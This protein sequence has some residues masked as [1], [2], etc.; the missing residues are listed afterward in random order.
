MNRMSKIK[1]VTPML[2]L[3]PVFQMVEP[4]ADVMTSGRVDVSRRSPRK[5]KVICS[6]DAL[7]KKNC[8]SR[9]ARIET[10]K[11]ES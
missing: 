7:V 5:K 6:S 2:P 11:T 10:T 9:T 8:R 4:D 3:V 1:A